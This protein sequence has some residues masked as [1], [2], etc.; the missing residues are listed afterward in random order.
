MKYMKFIV[1]LAIVA[2]MLMVA[3]P[4]AA[5]D[6]FGGPPSRTS[7]NGTTTWA[8]IYV[9]D[10]CSRQTLAAGSSRFY[11]ADT[12]KSHDLVIVVDDVPQWGAAFNYFGYGASA[13][14][15]QPSKTQGN[16]NDPG[17]G[18]QRPPAFYLN[19]PDGTQE[20]E[21]IHGFAA[22]VYGTEFIMDPDYYWPTPNN[23][24][25]TTR[26]GSRARV[27]DTE[28]ARGGY[29]RA[30]FSAATWS[31]QGSVVYPVLWL[32]NNPNK[33][34]KFDGETHLLSGEMQ[35]ADGWVYSR[36]FNNMIWDNDSNVCTK[37]VR[38]GDVDF[39]GSGH[40]I[41][42]FGQVP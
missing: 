35:K 9:A 13:Y 27:A 17:G 16:D 26:A 40:G 12:W 18:G 1:P 4:A 34:S 29:G 25:L 20:P 8:A 10:T 15:L 31:T 32:R 19:K 22:V 23:F 39:P 37:R 30:G 24:L 6:P 38:R 14:T 41:P 2:V 5:D 7:G 21:N 11:K 42:A 28:G 36:V 33:L 3:L